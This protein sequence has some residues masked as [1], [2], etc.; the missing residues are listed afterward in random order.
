MS[1]LI[2]ANGLQRIKHMMFVCHMPQ[3]RLLTLPYRAQGSSPQQHWAKN[4]LLHWNRSMYGLQTRSSN[5][6][7]T[8]RRSSHLDRRSKMLYETS[9]K[10]VFDIGYVPTCYTTG[11]WPDG[12]SSREEV[13]HINH[14]AEEIGTIQGLK[15]SFHPILNVI[16]LALD[17][18]PVFMRTKALR[19]L[20]QIVT[21]DSTLLSTVCHQRYFISEAKANLQPA[22]CLQSHGR[23]PPQQLSR[24]PWC[25]SGA[26][27]EVYGRFAWSCRGLL[28]KD[29]GSHCSKP[30]DVQ[31]SV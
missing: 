28:W 31:T 14:L 4:S 23:P 3:Y 20:G 17:A 7:L 10:T 13:V 25:S 26:H 8:I 15:N 30:L 29:R 22:S 27:R 21:S 6:T 24:S 5:R 12:L 11:N 2:C 1:L 9:G 19:A 18:P 16:L